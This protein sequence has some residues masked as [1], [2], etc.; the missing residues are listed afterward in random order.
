MS[1]YKPELEFVDKNP[2]TVVHVV[3]TCTR[4]KKAFGHAERRCALGI[5]LC[6]P[7]YLELLKN[8]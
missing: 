6:R 5:K 4:C 3:L 1:E 8:H 2:N 7:C